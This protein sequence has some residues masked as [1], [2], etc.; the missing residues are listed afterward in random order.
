MLAAAQN[1]MKKESQF[2][3]KYPRDPFPVNQTH[4]H[5]LKRGAGGRVV[6]IYSSITK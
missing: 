5:P 4:G 6:S 3:H 2:K 1:F